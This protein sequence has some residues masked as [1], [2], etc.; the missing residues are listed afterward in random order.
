MSITR[1]DILG[2]IAR[3]WCHPKNE[4]KLMD[5]ELAVAA[6]DEVETLIIEDEARDG[7]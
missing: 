6:A 2:A 5:E 3:A 4:H 1:E 7:S